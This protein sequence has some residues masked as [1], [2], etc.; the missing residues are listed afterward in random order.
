MDV[1]LN[2]NCDFDYITTN[3]FIFWSNKSKYRLCIYKYTKTVRSNY[4]KLKYGEKN[5]KISS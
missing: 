5:K 1:N 2:S 3:R 4:A